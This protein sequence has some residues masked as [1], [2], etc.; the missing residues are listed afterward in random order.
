MTCEV[1][2]GK[3]TVATVVDF[4]VDPPGIASAARDPAEAHPGARSVRCLIRDDAAAILPQQTV[5]TNHWK[6][7]RSE[8]SITESAKHT[9]DCLRG[10][11]RGY[12]LVPVARIA[13]IREPDVFSHEAEPLK[14]VQDRGDKS[15]GSHCP[16]GDKHQDVHVS[17]RGAATSIATHR[18]RGDLRAPLQVLC[19][20]SVDN[21]STPLES[22]NPYTPMIGWG[23]QETAQDDCS[24]GSGHP[25]IRASHGI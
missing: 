22:E 2:Y 4:Q 10:S 14:A 5:K 25:S 8:V 13:Q 23:S 12:L 16:A 24:V 1:V 15:V 20:V 11:I 19:C 17:A 7:R 3:G 21:V 6:Q 18:L 9:M